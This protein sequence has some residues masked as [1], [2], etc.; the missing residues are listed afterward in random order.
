MALLTVLSPLVFVADG[1]C[2]NSVVFHLALLVANQNI[3][4]R[5]PTAG[6]PLIPYG[7]SEP[8]HYCLP[9]PRQSAW[10]W[11]SFWGCFDD[12][13]DLLAKNNPVNLQEVT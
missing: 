6:V 8:F 5:W 4:G 11:N 12:F 13:S 3:F 9:I 10:R 2:L 7:R 1:F